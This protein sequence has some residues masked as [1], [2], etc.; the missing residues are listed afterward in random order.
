MIWKFV[1]SY[2]RYSRLN[3]S[4]GRLVAP[5]VHWDTDGSLSSETSKTNGILKPRLSINILRYLENAES[6]R[7]IEIPYIM[8]VVR[9]YSKLVVVTVCA[10]LDCIAFLC[11]LPRLYRNTNASIVGEI[12]ITYSIVIVSRLDDRHTYKKMLNQTNKYKNIN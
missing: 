8:S 3:M 11:S 4:S 9:K 1:C 2:I 10:C 7:N 6:Y 12:K 5:S